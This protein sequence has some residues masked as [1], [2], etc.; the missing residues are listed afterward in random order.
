MTL[1]VLVQISSSFSLKEINMSSFPVVLPALFLT[2]QSNRSG[3]CE[4]LWPQPQCNGQCCTANGPWPQWSHV[5]LRMSFSLFKHLQVNSSPAT[6]WLEKEEVTNRSLSW[7]FFF[8]LLARLFQ[9]LYFYFLLLFCLQ[10]NSKNGN[11]GNYKKAETQTILCSLVVINGL[12]LFFVF[13]T[14]LLFF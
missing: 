4:F 7:C 9:L 10:V 11:N 14:L 1:R 2:F 13:F 12:F 8:V 5:F 6:I 3:V